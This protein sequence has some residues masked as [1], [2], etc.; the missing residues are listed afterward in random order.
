M[1]GFTH[2]L[3][4]DEY[5]EMMRCVEEGVGTGCSSNGC[6]VREDGYDEISEK[7]RY[8]LSVIG[9]GK[10]IWARP[11]YDGLRVTISPEGKILEDGY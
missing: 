5:V 2:D 7:V 3:T 6:N 10:K 1:V 8:G 4:H 9:E 11:A